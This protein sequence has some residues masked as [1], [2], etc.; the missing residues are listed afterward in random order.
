MT[1]LILGGVQNKTTTLILSFQERKACI[2]T[3]GSKALVRTKQ[4]PGTG[5]VKQNGSS[6]ILRLP[7]T[8]KLIS[9]IIVQVYGF[10]KL[11]TYRTKI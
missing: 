6:G 5:Q 8:I 10:R 3:T 4:P 9:L 7:T 11:I 2:D 1:P